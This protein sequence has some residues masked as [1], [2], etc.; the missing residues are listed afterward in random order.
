[1]IAVVL[2]IVAGLLVPPAELRQVADARS[3]RSR[4]SWVVPSSENQACA[5]LAVLNLPAQLTPGFPYRLQASTNL[6]NWIGLS[7]N[8]PGATPF[9]FTGPLGP[10]YPGRFYRLVT[11]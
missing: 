1:M 6:M 8:T 2:V 3:F 5:E 10:V 4:A 11:P 7:T 9:T